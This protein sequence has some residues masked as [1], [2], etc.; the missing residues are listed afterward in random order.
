[1]KNKILDKISGE[2][3]LTILRQLAKNDPKIGKQ[4]EK[5]AEKLLKK[6]DLEE[7][8]EDVYSVL[9]GIGV[10][11]LW[12]RSGARRYGYSS[13]EEMAV[14]MMEEELEPY[15]KEVVKYLELGMAKEAKLYCMGVLKGIYQYEQE[16]KSE[17]KDWAADVSGECFG[18]LL[19]EWKKRINNKD[20]LIEMDKFLEKECSKW[21]KWAVKI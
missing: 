21:A 11:E 2:E 4:I 15:N 14:E 13:P 18:Y 6:V 17:F 12:D 5:E 1:M 16:S 8:C 9:D 7:I 10:E 3:A 20:D 19:E